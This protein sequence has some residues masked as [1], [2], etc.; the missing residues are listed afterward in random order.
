MRLQTRLMWK[1]LNNVEHFQGNRQMAIAV[2]M[3]ARIN[4]SLQKNNSP[5]DKTP[6]VK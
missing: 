2:Y 4:P 1:T 5:Q 6:I 3:T